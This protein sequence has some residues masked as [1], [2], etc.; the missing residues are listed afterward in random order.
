[1]IRNWSTSGKGRMPFES[2]GQLLSDGRRA[3]GASAATKLSAH[4]HIH[5]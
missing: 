2:H 3:V 1:M 4:T 5:T